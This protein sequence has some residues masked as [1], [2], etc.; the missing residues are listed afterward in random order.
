GRCASNPG[1]RAPRGPRRARSRRSDSSRGASS[2]SRPGCGGREK[3]RSSTGRGGARPR[4]APA[5]SRSARPPGTAPR[6]ASHE[7]PRR[8]AGRRLLP[9]RGVTTEGPR[10]EGLSMPAASALVFGGWEVRAG[11]LLDA[12]TELAESAR[13]FDPRLLDRLALDLQEIDRNIVN[14]ETRGSPPPCVTVEDAE[15]PAEVVQRLGGDLRA[16]R[17]RHSLERVVVVNLATTEPVFT[18]PEDHLTLAGLEESLRSGG[19]AVFRP[20]TLYAYAAMREGA[21]FINFAASPAA[22]ARAIRELA[23]R[24]GVPFAGTDGKTG[25]ALVKS[26]LAS[27]FRERD[28]QVLAWHGDNV[29]GNSDGAALNAPEVKAAKVETKDGVV[30]GVLGY[31]P[32]TSVE[33]TYV[34]SLGDWKTAWDLIHFQG[35]LG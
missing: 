26:A 22:L 3:A 17:R 12:A 5:R 21:A 35:F 34:P 31:S 16:F 6:D 15:T 8:A 30:R 4:Q 20:S 10:G 19:S 33:I 7:S 23:E 32:E 24:E 25:E 18:T 2:A 9:L 28:L 29:L 27:L 13:I 14:G 1:R 11:S